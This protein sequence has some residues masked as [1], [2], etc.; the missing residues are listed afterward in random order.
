M[1]GCVLGWIHD[2]VMAERSSEQWYFGIKFNEFITLFRRNFLRC[3]FLSVDVPQTE[4]KLR[5]KLVAK[6]IIKFVNS[7]VI[8]VISVLISF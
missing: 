7:N 6:D 4:T 2:N 1:L 3:E 5:K 8:H